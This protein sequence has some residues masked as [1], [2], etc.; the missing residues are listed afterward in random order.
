MKS[1]LLLLF[2]FSF[3]ILRAQEFFKSIPVDQLPATE[4]GKART[5]TPTAYSAWQLNLSA[6]SAAIQSA[7]MEFTTAAYYNNTSVVAIPQPDGRTEDLRCNRA[8]KRFTT[9]TPKSGLLRVAR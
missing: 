1:K 9:N 7:P 5:W 3:S 2:L 6:L 4:N 8:S